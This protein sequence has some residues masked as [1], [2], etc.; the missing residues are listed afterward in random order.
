MKM[1]KISIVIILKT[2]LLISIN[3][4]VKYGIGSDANF[5]ASIVKS[6]GLS[7][8]THEV[9]Y[10]NGQIKKI[11]HC[12]SN[13]FVLESSTNFCKNY[14]IGADQKVES[15]MVIYERY[16]LD[17][18]K[19][20]YNKNTTKLTSGWLTDNADSYITIDLSN[21][22]H[23]YVL[24]QDLNK[25]PTSDQSSL[26]IVQQRK[27]ELKTRN[28]KIKNERQRIEDIRSKQYNLR[29]FRSE[30][31]LFK[32]R[33]LMFN[34]VLGQYEI[35]NKSGYSYSKLFR[36]H[37]DSISYKIKFI[38]K[39]SGE[40]DCSR[41]HEILNSSE[42]YGDQE[43]WRLFSRMCYLVPNV[44]I[45]GVSVDTYFEIENFKIEYHSGITSVKIKK[46]GSFKYQE[47]NPSD[48]AKKLIE[49]ELKTKGRGRYTIEYIIIKSLGFIYNDVIIHK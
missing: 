5:V 16:S 45:D 23:P 4:Q 24:F 2:F 8:S 28:D 49:D 26:A 31:E 1:K 15:I 43:H 38:N 32:L 30:Q 40:Y 6:T 39:Y 35:G 11:S 3:A 36:E 10:F 18:V 29:D 9:K 25:I 33:K 17:Y 34:S 44:E 19:E 41:E 37:S 14:I 20:W 46:D 7:N 13:A 48:L 47:T 22:G 12:F 27:H 42:G 21:S